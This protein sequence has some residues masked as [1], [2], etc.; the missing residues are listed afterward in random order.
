[1]CEGV[2]PSSTTRSPIFPL[3]TFG[4][5]LLRP[6]YI[7]VGI[8]IST[9][10]RYE[11]KLLS[12]QKDASPAH[13]CST[14]RANASLSGI[15]RMSSVSTLT[16]AVRPVAD[17]VWRIGWRSKI[18]TDHHRSVISEHSVIWTER[19]TH[20]ERPYRAMSGPVKFVLATLAHR[21]H[22]RFSASRQS[23]DGWNSGRVSRNPLR[24]DRA[25]KSVLMPRLFGRKQ[26]GR[27]D[28]LLFSVLWEWFPVRPVAP[29]CNMFQSTKRA[30][31]TAAIP[32]SIPNTNNAVNSCAALKTRKPRS[33]ADVRMPPPRP[34]VCASMRYSSSRVSGL[35]FVCRSRGKCWR[36]RSWRLTEG[37]KGCL[38]VSTSIRR[39]CGLARTCIDLMGTPLDERAASS[40]SPCAQSLDHRV[41]A[42]FR[43]SD[44][45]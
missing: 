16:Q 37:T 11:P 8:Y 20:A 34:M 14:A 38:S 32:P 12:R 26:L 4:Q 36:S 41:G 15:D 30:I 28:C 39:N 35:P 21:S 19:H 22:R 2:Y 13:I 25:S 29:V 33:L 3:H 45:R 27:L 24:F 42:E 10:K 44:G 31:K 23:Q 40:L 6:V 1:M 43:Q 7:E 18:I 5:G 9:I 17:Y